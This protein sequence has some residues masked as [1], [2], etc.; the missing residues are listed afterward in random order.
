MSL[1]MHYLLRAPY[2]DRTIPQMPVEG[3]EMNKERRWSFQKKTVGGEKMINETGVA[4]KRAF[5]AARQKMVCELIGGKKGH[6][7]E[8]PQEELKLWWLR[9]KN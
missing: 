7:Q 3:T 5:S 2:L 4:V 8:L 9:M 6:R 1:R